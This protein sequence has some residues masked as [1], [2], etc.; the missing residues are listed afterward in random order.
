LREIFR[1]CNR[2]FGIVTQ[3]PLRPYQKEQHKREMNQFKSTRLIP[4][5]KHTFGK[6]RK[7]PQRP[8]KP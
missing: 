8:P 7:K 2:H 5:S 3:S 4:Q 1:E 6:H